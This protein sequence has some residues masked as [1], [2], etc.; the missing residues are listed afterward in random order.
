MG[1][2]GVTANGYGVSLGD[3]ENIL[4]LNSSDGCTTLNILK[5]TELYTLKR[6]NVVVCGLHLK[7]M[8]TGRNSE[9]L[10][11]LWWSSG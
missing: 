6:V 9:G 1:K 2:S 8:C 5:P 4:K 3:N 7:V 10:L 11:W